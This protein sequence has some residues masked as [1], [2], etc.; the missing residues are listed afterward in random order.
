MSFYMKDFF[1][2]GLLVSS[3][4]TGNSW[5][6]AATG[7]TCCRLVSEADLGLDVTQAKYD[8]AQGT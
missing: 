1:L 5:P 2:S 4:I 3:Y 6:A 8:R 7:S